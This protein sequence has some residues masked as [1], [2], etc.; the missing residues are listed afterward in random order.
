M[1]IPQEIIPAIISKLRDKVPE[2][3]NT[4][5][6]ILM[7]MWKRSPLPQEILPIMSTIMKDIAGNKYHPRIDSEYCWTTLLVQQPFLDSETTLVLLTRALANCDNDLISDLMN[8]HVD[9]SSLVGLDVRCWENLCEFLVA[10]AYKAI[11]RHLSSRRYC[12]RFK[13]DGCLYV[14]WNQKMIQISNGY[15]RSEE[16]VRV[17]LDAKASFF[18][19]ERHT[20]RPIDPEDEGTTNAYNAWIENTPDFTTLFL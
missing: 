5:S 8:K 1:L 13:L 19:R 12:H 16:L 2:N 3:E 18:R 17:T 14:Y 15:A 7:A 6:H 10:I 20:Y 9:S 4:R 11:S